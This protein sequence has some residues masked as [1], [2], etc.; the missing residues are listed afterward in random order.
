MLK[1]AT[2]FT[3]APS[4]ASSGFASYKKSFYSVCW[5]A[6]SFWF[7]EWYFAI[8]LLNLYERVSLFGKDFRVLD[9]SEEALQ[10]H[11]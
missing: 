1:K 6:A 7:Y 10:A 8:L 5:L 9:E 4:A 3:D 11:Q 2:S